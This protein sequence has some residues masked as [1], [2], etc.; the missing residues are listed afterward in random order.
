[1]THGGNV[2]QGDRPGD[3]LDLSASVRPG[4]PPPWVREAL[5]SAMDRLEYYPQLSMARS[6]AAQSCMSLNFWEAEYSA[7]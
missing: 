4:G 6:R 3:W 2:W 1:M 7:I 5:L